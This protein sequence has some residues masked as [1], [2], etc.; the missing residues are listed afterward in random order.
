M[1]KAIIIDDEYHAQEGLKKLI[2]HTAPNFFSNI[3]VAD[4]VNHGVELIREFKPDLVFLDIHLPNEYGFK[5]FDYFDEINFEII[6]TTAHSNYVLEAVNQW[7]CLGYLMKPI[8][9]SDLEFVLDRF[10]N[11]LNQ[12]KSKENSD[13]LNP[14]SE[15]FEVVNEIKTTLNQ[16]NGILLF[17]SV[18]ELNFIKIDEIIYCKASDNYCEIYTISK[19]FTISKPLKEIEKSINRNVFVRVHRSYLVNLDYAVRLDK[20]NNILIV[21]NP[22]LDTASEILVPVTASGLKILVNAIS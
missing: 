21:Q 6:F 5:L 12:K 3:L 10:K 1:Y 9:I 20:R 14:N 16:E 15:E 2:A 4:S 22:K 17:S 13:S 8:S 11:V 18:N 19:S 7:G